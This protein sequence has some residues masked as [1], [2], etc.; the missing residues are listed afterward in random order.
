MWEG[1]YRHSQPDRHVVDFWDL[2]F[3]DGARL[4][5]S[6]DVMGRS[7]I[8]VCDCT[9]AKSNRLRGKGRVAGHGDLGIGIVGG[10]TADA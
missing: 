6:V 10:M 7:C 9:R 1:R 3:P 4:D 8:G 5:D 2:L